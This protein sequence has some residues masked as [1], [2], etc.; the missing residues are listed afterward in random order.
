[1]PAS[2][3]AVTQVSLSGL[4]PVRSGK[5]REM[6]DLGACYLMVATDRV[7]AFDVVMPN[8][9]P[10]KGKILNQLSAFWFNKL[11]HIVPNHL[12]SCDDR[13]IARE[14]GSPYDSA[15][16]SGRC[17]LVEKCE[18]VPIE[19]VA[20]GFLAGSL[21]KE[22]VA[23][24]GLEKDVVLHGISLRKGLALGEHLDTPIYTPATKAQ[25]GHDENISLETAAKAVGEAVAA[26]C[27]VI[28]LRLFSA[29]AAICSQN[30]LLL[31]DTKFE[32]GTDSTGN[33][34]L[35]DE[36]LTPDSSRFW[37]ADTYSPGRPQESLDKQYIRDFLEKLDW[38]KT[39]PA[40]Q[41]PDD[42]VSETRRR[43]IKIFELLTGEAPKL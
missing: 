21:Y 27:R 25:S 28:T 24:G 43:Y 11:S 13:E 6:Y 17:M 18:P 8:G 5:V 16:L 36:A 4:Q 7:S 14:V 35:I 1:M 20:R 39:P 10:D 34:K 23:S 12:I 15:Q 19:S 41:L 30:G 22:Y 3:S 33:L 29:A 2:T 32:F 9:I 42:V 40:P 26:D 31:A 37:P 38:N